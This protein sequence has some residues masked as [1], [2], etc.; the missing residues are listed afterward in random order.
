MVQKVTGKN[1]WSFLQTKIIFCLQILH[2]RQQNKIYTVQ[3]RVSK[4]IF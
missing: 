3:Q 2:E 1:C 4:N